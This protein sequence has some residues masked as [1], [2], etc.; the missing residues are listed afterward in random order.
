MLQ[1]AAMGLQEGREVWRLSGEAFEPGFIW[2][3]ELG[4]NPI[5]RQS[6]G[7]WCLNPV[8]SISSVWM[9][10][11]MLYCFCTFSCHCKTPEIAALL[12]CL[13][14]HKKIVF[15]MFF[16]I[17]MG[18]HVVVV[19]KSQCFRSKLNHYSRF[20]VVY[21]VPV[22]KHIL[23]HLCVCQ[24]FHKW[25]IITLHITFHYYNTHV[26]MLQL[27]ERVFVNCCGSDWGQC[28]HTFQL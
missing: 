3:V 28:S 25:N 21:S 15:K 19:W 26:I 4:L 16:F 2:R 10:Q 5:Y 1:L 27:L 23:G 24:S 12:Y 7:C 20:M 6:K 14:S 9:N 22:L 17:F 13:W 18:V 8:S 11:W